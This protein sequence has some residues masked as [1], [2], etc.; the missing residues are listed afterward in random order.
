MLLKINILLG[1]DAYIYEYGFIG[2]IV[3]IKNVKIEDRIL[4]LRAIQ[5]GCP[6]S[7]G[8]L[9]QRYMPFFLKYI[10][11][12]VRLNDE[13]LD[14]VQA[15]FLRLCQGNCKYNGQS[16]VQAYLC[17]IAKNVLRDHFKAKNRQI[18]AVSL[19]EIEIDGN[20]LVTHNKTAEASKK[21]Q[22]EEIREVLK[23]TVSK[24]PEKASQAIELVCLQ[25]L[26]PLDA[27]RKVG[28]SIETFYNR[29]NHGRRLMKSELSEYAKKKES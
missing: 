24:L 11:R 13:S 19:D 3:R 15:I 8:K 7:M 12:K 4:L 23:K 17:G 29:L 10:S 27:C 20:L 18:K 2:G 26:R 22:S 28:C 5:D 14:L 6:E 16:D 1:G 9:Y 21:L 25:G